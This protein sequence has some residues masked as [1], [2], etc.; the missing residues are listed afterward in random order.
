MCRINA[1]AFMGPKPDDYVE[2][3]YDADE[4]ILLEMYAECLA[5]AD[6]LR[7]G[8]PTTPTTPERTR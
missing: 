3:R 2:D 7:T 1:R 6:S 4:R 8:T 5:Y